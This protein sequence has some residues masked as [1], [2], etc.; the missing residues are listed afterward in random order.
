MHTIEYLNEIKIRKASLTCLLPFRLSQ[1]K[2]NC[3]CDETL[4]SNVLDMVVMDDNKLEHVVFTV[5][6][7][8]DLV[9]LSLA[10]SSTCSVSRLSE[11]EC[12]ADSV[13]VHHVS[14]DSVQKLSA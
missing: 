6:I 2:I 4:L 11:H 3:G 14:V 5:I 9:F 10:T 13:C 8:D 1:N 7:L 12:Y